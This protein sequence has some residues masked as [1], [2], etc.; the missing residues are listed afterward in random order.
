MSLLAGNGEANDRG[1]EDVEAGGE[2]AA[3][4]AEETAPRP[5]TGLR[6]PDGEEREGGVH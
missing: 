1:A 5:T 6:E 4:I 2:E 3:F